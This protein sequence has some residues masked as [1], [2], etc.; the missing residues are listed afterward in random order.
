MVHKVF[1]LK[2]IDN[3]EITAKFELTDPDTY[4]SFTGECYIA[5]SWSVDY[6][7]VYDYEFVADVYC[8]WDGCTH[9]W[10]RG[11]DYVG[12][13]DNADSYYHLC[14]TPCFLTHIRCMCFVWKLAYQTMIDSGNDYTMEE[15]FDVAPATELVSL[16][17]NGYEIVEEIE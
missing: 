17:L 9:W 6:N 12:E 3:G 16:M 10:F 8:K 5:T 1:Y 14:G 11:E 2:K 13:L 15:Y 7:E 4:H